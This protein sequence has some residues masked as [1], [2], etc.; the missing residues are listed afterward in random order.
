V[1][2]LDLQAI[3]EKWLNVC[4]SCDA[5]LPGQCTHPDE[6]YRPTMLSLVNEV[7]RLHTWAGLMS[8]LDDEHY[9]ASVFPTEEDR[10]ER[11][12]GPRIISLIRQ[13]DEAR[14]EVERLKARCE[15]LVNYWP[16]GRCRY[17]SGRFDGSRPHAMYCRLY[18]G[19]LTHEWVRTGFNGT[20]GGI[21]HVCRCGGWFRQGGLAGHGDGSDLAEPICPN[22]DQT[23]RG[24]R[25]EAS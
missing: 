19:P 25:L 5:G 8:L 12:P 17:C 13:L 6:D 2:E 3:R 20:F 15:R 22:A 16:D 4:P 24:Q 23:H 9:P 18:E 1:N 10:D 11:D 7:E 21:D 14:N